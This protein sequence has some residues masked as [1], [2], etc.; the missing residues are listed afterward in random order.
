[1]V[2]M[3]RK[4]CHNL[5]FFKAMFPKLIG[6]PTS[7]TFQFFYEKL[8]IFMH[9][10]PSVQIFV[11]FLLSNIIE[12]SLNI[13]ENNLKLKAPSMNIKSNYFNSL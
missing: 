5:I 3:Y 8:V 13:F 4:P 10:K 2:L 7:T 6:G 1:M 11:S 9:W 12:E